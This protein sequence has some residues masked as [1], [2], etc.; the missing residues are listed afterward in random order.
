ML[1]KWIQNTRMGYI[2]GQTGIIRRVLREEGGWQSHLI[3]SNEYIQQ[4][5]KV[6]KSKSV[7][8]L[9]SGWLL[10]VPIKY[11]IDNCEEIILCDISHPNQIINKYS[12]CNKIKFETIDITGGIVDFCYSQMKKGFDVES[13]V[14][15][16]SNWETIRYKDEMVVSVNLLS[17][18]SVM[19]T[20]YLTKKVNL[21]GDPIRIISE[22]IQQKHIESLP[23][24][25][26]VLISDVEEEYYD[27][28]DKFIGSKPTVF[29]DFLKGTNQSEW[30]WNFDS[31]MVYKD[32][33]KT[34][35]KVTALTL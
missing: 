28:D 20:D 31:K 16:L 12:T 9:G 29:V 15:T 14:Y 4:A 1:R 3:K 7:R 13:F 30:L 17:Q 8:I 2:S 5:V 23:L 19:I 35:L 24:G 32:D 21:K 26:S 25:R 10:D 27:E 33:C 18:L 22:I 11:L 6:Q 34:K